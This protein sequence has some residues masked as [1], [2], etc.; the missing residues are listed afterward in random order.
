MHDM[1]GMNANQRNLSLCSRCIV[2]SV[3]VYLFSRG[4][5]RRTLQ[6]H[7]HC[8]CIWNEIREPE[9]SPERTPCMYGESDCFNHYYRCL[10][11]SAPS[12]DYFF[13]RGHFRFCHTHLT[14]NGLQ[15]TSKSCINIY[16]PSSGGI[17]LSDHKKSDQIQAGAV[18]LVS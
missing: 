11:L 13:N 15:S 14:A 5:W 2:L 10:S 17:R 7:H 4:F 3:S 8:L 12:S 18:A 16:F 9:A 6:T 1:N